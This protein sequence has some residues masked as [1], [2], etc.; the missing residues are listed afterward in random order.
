MATILSQ[1]TTVTVE[2]GAASTAVIGGIVGMSGIGSGSATEIDITS[3]AST[4]KEYRQGLQDNGT[5]TFE[6]LRDE[7]DAGQVE[8]REMQAAQ[9]TR[10]FVITLSSSTL[11]VLTFNGFVTSLTSDIG[12][13]DIVRGTCAVKITG[14]ITLS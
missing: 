3:L 5:L 12:A 8:L 11:N 10:E 2:D 6:L 13:D 4:R 14:A 9:A 1:G 7:D